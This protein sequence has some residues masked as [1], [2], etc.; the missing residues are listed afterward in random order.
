[1]DLH[2]KTTTAAWLFERMSNLA[3]A[4]P[5]F[6]EAFS[7]KDPVASFSNEARQNAFDAGTKLLRIR[8]ATVPAKS[9]SVVGWDELLERLEGIGRDRAVYID[10][11]DV[12]VLLVE[13]FGRGMGG[14]YD[15]A[16]GVD[17]TPGGFQAFACGIGNSSKG[18]GS[19]GSKGIGRTALMVA[20]EAR[21]LFVL[22]VREEDR[23]A[24]FFGLSNLDLHTYQGKGYRAEGQ[25]L[26]PTSA[27]GAAADEITA[28]PLVDE[29]AYA[30]AR[31][32]G[33]DRKEGEFGTTMLIP[34]V[35]KE[36]TK[37]NFIETLVKEHFV[38]VINGDMVYELV[39]EEGTT[40]IDRDTILE[41]AGN[42]LFGGAEF[43]EQM[44]MARDLFES[45]E[46][47]TVKH[48]LLRGR[49]KPDVIG[50]A[51]LD[52]LAADFKLNKPVS[53]EVQFTARKVRA[54]G[55]VGK[56][57]I[58]AMASDRLVNGL[59]ILV[60]DGISKITQRTG[61]PYVTLV[62]SR[63]DSVAE[64][65]RDGEDASH[66]NWAAST[67]REKGWAFTLTNDVCATFEKGGD[68]LLD[69]IMKRD[70]KEDDTVFADI[71]SM[72]RPDKK[73]VDASSKTDVDGDE[74]R[75]RN[76]EPKPVPEPSE[77]N[78]TPVDI[79]L[80]PQREDGQWGFKV[81]MSARGRKVMDSAKPYNE[82]MIGAVF[83]VGEGRR[84]SIDN[85][86]AADFDLSKFTFEATG[87][88]VSEVGV[89]DFTITDLT[90]DFSVSVIGH[91][92][93]AREIEIG[94]LSAKEANK[95]KGA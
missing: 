93:D 36:F 45:M 20:S 5:I 40:T 56:L 16:S 89:R 52:L 39:D 10:D 2:L 47:P 17:E 33:I 83:A 70:Y 84:P 8:W 18:R 22:T 55:E 35:R 4:R 92:G 91:F 94:L 88:T 51:N 95:K 6:Q 42:P 90:P 80:I 32:I 71:F 82:L 28:S 54:K 7:V 81:T 43:V 75:E 87:C 60:R 50:D 37:K 31:E 14:K 13:D 34:A 30:I 76:I 19:S 77:Q 46:T 57:R 11:G 27:A 53:L 21:S 44:R 24:L 59:Q 69:A 64:M 12:R 63:D 49:I 29:D 66:R 38:S 85:H 78:P 23:K 65:L 58:G 79:H 73:T 68:T 1:M 61:R 74:D 15:R 26:V 25:F 72:P 62:I 41:L 48:G 86:S 3:N 9:L 67:M